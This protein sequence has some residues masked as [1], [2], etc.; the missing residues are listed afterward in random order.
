MELEHDSTDQ[1]VECLYQG[2]ASI[3]FKTPEDNVIYVDPYDKVKKGYE[4]TADVILITD[5]RH[6]KM[7]PS[8]DGWQN[9]LYNSVSLREGKAS[10]L[11]KGEEDAEIVKG[12]RKVI[13]EFE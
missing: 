9:I 11:I 12:L 7:F 10:E 5:M 4:E 2:H 1:A 8:M 3:R 6:R 13:R